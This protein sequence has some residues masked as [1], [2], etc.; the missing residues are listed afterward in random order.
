M[1]LL[2]I[3]A[4]PK[5]H[6][7]GRFIFSLCLA[8]WLRW[9]GWPG[10]TWPFCSPR[11]WP[12][13]SLGRFHLAL[14]SFL[15]I[16]LY[17]FYIRFS[18]LRFAAAAANQ[19]ISLTQDCH[20]CDWC[21]GIEPAFVARAKIDTRT[22]SEKFMVLMFLTGWQPS[23][24]KFENLDATIQAGIGEYTARNKPMEW[25]AWSI[26]QVVKFMQWQ[27]FKVF[28]KTISDG[29]LGGRAWE[30]PAKS[31]SGEPAPLPSEV[32][33]FHKAAS[34]LFVSFTVR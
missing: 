16:V 4:L 5:C 1:N 29:C 20:V 34:H 10:V 22:R 8:V 19:I 2:P 21:N 33:E 17:R 14:E 18:W 15:P 32:E 31:A 3:C 7:F 6:S 11:H 13:P 24:A 26:D 23:D 9:A 12:F 30:L 27:L 25:T 28:D